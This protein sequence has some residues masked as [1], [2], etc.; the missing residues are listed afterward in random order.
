MRAP[1]PI[2]FPD[3]FTAEP[4]E[5]FLAT[6]GDFPVSEPAEGSWNLFFPP[7]VFRLSIFGKR[8]FVQLCFFDF[9]PPEGYL[10]YNVS[11]LLFYN[12]VIPPCFPLVSFPS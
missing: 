4:C 7:N 9:F 5:S 1:Q 8:F 3:V 6:E 10:G 11:V 2:I 12:P